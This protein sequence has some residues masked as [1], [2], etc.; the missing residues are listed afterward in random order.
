MSKLQIR[1]LIE[2][3]MPVDGMIDTGIAGVKLFRATE[4]VP[5]VPAVYEPCVIAIVSGGKETVLDG[6][7][8][9]YDS[10]EYMCCP[11][12]MP[13]EAGTPA[14]SAETPLYGVYIALDQ[15]LMTQITIEM[16]AAGDNMHPVEGSA[17]G[18]RLA[19]WDDRFLE[20]LLRL[21][22][23][24]TKEP[25]VAVLGEA[26]LRE[27]Y[28]AILTGEAGQF[29]RQAF[30]PGNAIARAISDVSSQLAEPVSVDNMAARAGMSRAVFY[31][32]FKQATAMTPTQFIKAMR[33]N[34]AAMKIASGV[35]VSE[36]AQDVGYVSASQFSRE[37]KRL[38][39]Q[40]PRQWGEAQAL[41]MALG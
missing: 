5:C 30:A 22:Q 26:R 25:D 15:R 2:A 34:N 23:L 12:S 39:G 33:L 24:G 37:F 8:Y 7:R 31:R 10:S 32:R 13:V 27:L 36:A 3:R 17:R 20:S 38:Y 16:D 41:P 28:Y 9:V 1:Q 18:I 11:M 21:V 40:S 29:A 6:K 35:T 19:R 4:A 14:A